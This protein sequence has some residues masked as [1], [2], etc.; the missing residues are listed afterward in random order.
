V[1][2]IVAAVVGAGVTF[3]AL[4]LVVG[5][6]SHVGRRKQAIVRR[7]RGLIVASVGMQFV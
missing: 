6:G 2:A 3:A 5:M 7:F 4:L 1:T